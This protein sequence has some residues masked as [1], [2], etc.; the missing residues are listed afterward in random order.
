MPDVMRIENNDASILYNFLDSTNLQ[1]EEETQ[2]WQRSGDNKVTETMILA[3]KDDTV[4][5]I[6]SEVVALE[7]ILEDASR[8]HRDK[9]RNDPYWWRWVTTGESAKRALIYDYALF[10]TNSKTFSPHLTRA[11]AAYQLAVT[12]HRAYENVTPLT[13]SVNGLTASG[14]I[15]NISGTIAAG[16]LDGRIGKLTIENTASGGASE[17]IDQVWVGIRPFR[18]GVSTFDPI[19]E[20]EDAPGTTDTSDATAS[21]GKYVNITLS[22]ISTQK[23][24]WSLDSGSR[25]W[26][27]HVGTYLVLMRYRYSNGSTLAGVS[28]S[29]TVGGSAAVNQEQYPPQTTVWHVHPLGEIEIPAFRVGSDIFANL[30][31]FPTLAINARSIEGAGTLHIDKI[32]LIPTEYFFSAGGIDEDGSTAI[33]GAS[34]EPLVIYTHPDD[35]VD[36]FTYS[37][38]GGIIRERPPI[39][40]N[41]WFY[42]AEGGVLVMEYDITRLSTI[43]VHSMSRTADLDIEVYPRWLT[44]RT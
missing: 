8:W 17:E 13:H 5:N 31:I 29:L 2:S 14:G 32:T 1:V 40:P 3:K 11:A 27:D 35:E 10:P 7:T 18:N 38:T 34:G 20:A 24:N 36:G 42:P 33:N 37:T 23:L 43:N 25:A 44:Y 21:G 28:A 22:S 12:R 6:R 19:F 39:Q 26:E 9:R 41:N 4:A 15:W 16:L 30:S